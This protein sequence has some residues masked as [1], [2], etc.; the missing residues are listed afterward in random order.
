MNHQ[1]SETAP[2]DC[3]LTLKV[4]PNPAICL[5]VSNQLLDLQVDKGRPVYLCDQNCNKYIFIIIPGQIE[6]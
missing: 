3:K 6:L 5:C 4:K 2:N 1:R